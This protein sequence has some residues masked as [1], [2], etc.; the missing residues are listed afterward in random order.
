MM[1]R[2]LRGTMMGEKKTTVFS[3][4]VSMVASASSGS[5]KTRWTST[6][7]ALDFFRDLSEQ[8]L[9]DV[10]GNTIAEIFTM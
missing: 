1:T 8:Q 5:E 10:G 2:A 4:S 6:R 9:V 3:R 7:S